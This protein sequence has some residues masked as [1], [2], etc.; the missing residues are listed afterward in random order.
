MEKEFI[1][2]EGARGRFGREAFKGKT[3]LRVDLTDAKAAEFSGKTRRR[4]MEIAEKAG[5][6]TD[7]ELICGLFCGNEAKFLFLAENKSGLDMLRASVGIKAKLKS[8]ASEVPEGYEFYKNFLP[9]DEQLQRFNNEE[10]LAAIRALGDTGGQRR[11]NFHLAF[12]SEPDMAGFAPNA[13]REGF[14]LGSAEKSNGDDCMVGFA[15]HRICELTPSSVG[16]ATDKVIALAAP[17]GGKLL[18][19]DCPIQKRLKK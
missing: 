19:W 8:E 5:K 6:R 18:F 2:A 17:Y 11:L 14:A 3:L 12:R 4:F 9:T 7:S 10:I 16:A 15:V 13:L 1:V